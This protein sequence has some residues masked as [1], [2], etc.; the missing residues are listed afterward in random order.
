MSARS[1]IAAADKVQARA[2]EKALA[3]LAEIKRNHAPVTVCRGCGLRE[4]PG[5]CDWST[6]DSDQVTICSLCCTDV[7][8]Q[9]GREGQPRPVQVSEECVDSHD[10]APGRPACSTVEIIERAGL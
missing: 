3:A 2:A 7:G 1:V 10:H 6:G 9:T 5:D 8:A 4:C